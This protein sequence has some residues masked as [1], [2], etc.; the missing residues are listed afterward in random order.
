MPPL[1]Q[2]PRDLPLAYLLLNICCTTLPAAAL[3]F[4][5]RPASNLPGLAY[6]VANYVL[7]LQRFMLMLV[8]GCAARCCTATSR[9][10][11]LAGVR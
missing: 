9:V 1:L 2:D 10:V 5:A 6:L 7:Y 3:L 4:T 8:G 11:D